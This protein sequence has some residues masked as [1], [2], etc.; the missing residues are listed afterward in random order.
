MADPLSST[1]VLST[2]LLRS[3]AAANDNDDPDPPPAMSARVKARAASI[4]EAVGRP[5]VQLF[6][7]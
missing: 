6:A 2:N 7:A 4:T 5:L 1:R 3:W